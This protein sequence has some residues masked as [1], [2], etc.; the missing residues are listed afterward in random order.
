[1]EEL[2]AK[3]RTFDIA[4]ERAEKIAYS[5]N[6][7]GQNIWF[8]SNAILPKDEPMRDQKVHIKL[9]LPIGTRL[10]IPKEFERKINIQALSIWECENLYSTDE[11]PSFTEWE[12]TESGLK[13]IL[14]NPQLPLPNSIDSVQIDSTKN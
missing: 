6:Q 5:I 8:A 11:K 13:C 1:M 10:V 2:S 9:Y 7:E 12:M 14:P 4:A 3:G